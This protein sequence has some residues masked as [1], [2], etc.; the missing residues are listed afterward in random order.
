LE[1]WSYQQGSAS[2]PEFALRQIAAGKHDAAFLKIAGVIASSKEPAYLRFAHEFNGY[3]YP[4]A[5]GQN[6]NTNADY[7]AAWRHVRRLF[8]RAGALNAQWV[9]SPNTLQQ[10]GVSSDLAASYPGDLDVNL[11]G[12]TAYARR[13]GET[14]AQ[15]Y[16][17]TLA[18]LRK[19]TRKPVILSETGAAGATKASWLAALG[20]WLNQ[21][22]SVK[23]FVYYS[24]TPQTTGA[25]DD[26][27]ISTDQDA[28]A[29]R[30]TLRQAV[31]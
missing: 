9:W 27:A 13:S 22:P 30:R 29:L 4:W 7:V 17:R 16:D 31:G 24:T 10:S 26:Y 20:G 23:G 8:L 14:P 6:G 2:Q 21:Q 5:V 1:P 12:L 28:A 15:S 11:V 25:S 3:W 18:A 19:V